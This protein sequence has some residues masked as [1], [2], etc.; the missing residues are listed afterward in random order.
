MHTGMFHFAV[1]VTRGVATGGIWVYIP[2][3]ITSSKLFMGKNDVKM[4]VEHEY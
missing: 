4:A 2:Q 1:K 3:K